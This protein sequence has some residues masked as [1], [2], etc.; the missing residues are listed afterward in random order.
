MLS[1]LGGGDCMSRADDKLDPLP[2]QCNIVHALY[3]KHIWRILNHEMEANS[4]SRVLVRYLLQMKILVC[5][6]E[7]GD[8]KVYAWIKGIQESTCLD[9]MCIIRFLGNQ[10]GIWL[11]IGGLEILQFFSQNDRSISVINT[12]DIELHPTLRQLECSASCLN[13]LKHLFQPKSMQEW[14]IKIG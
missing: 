4:A 6:R 12:L 5:V 7:R 2:S 9:S 3:G 10:Y 14:A 8:I 1:W 11:C 13:I